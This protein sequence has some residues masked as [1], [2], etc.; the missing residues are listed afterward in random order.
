[1]TIRYIGLDFESSG[2][3]PWGKHVPIQIGLAMD[4]YE[5]APMATFEALIGGWKWTE[6]E[7]SEEAAQVHNLHKD[8][9]GKSD[10]VW[11]VDIRAA[12]WLLRQVGHGNRMWNITVGWNVAGFDRQFVTR[13]MP[14]LNRLLSYRTVDLNALV[15]ARSLTE[16]DYSLWKRQAKEYADKFNPDGERHDALVDAR[17][18]L[19]ER[20]FL[21]GEVPV[22]AV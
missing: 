15:F 5:G 22:E 3:D 2:S 21:V 13:W 20:K 16:A 8:D 7:W 18:A 1:M 14:N 17:A 19:L 10:P 4:T 9:I 6:W 12:E 11:V